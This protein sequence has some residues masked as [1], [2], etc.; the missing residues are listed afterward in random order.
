MQNKQWLV[1][2]T[3]AAAVAS[4]GCATIVH[5]GGGQE[6]AFTSSPPG[7]AVTIDNRVIGTTPTTAR[8]RRKTNH[9]VTLDLPGYASQSTTLDSGLSGWVFGNILLGGVI[10]LIVDA[11]TGGMY[12]L[13]PNGVHADFVPPAAAITPPL[14]APAATPVA[15][16]SVPSMPSPVAS[17]PA[18]PKT[19]APKFAKGSVVTLPAGAL[20]RDRPTANSSGHTTAQPEVVTLIS[21]NGTADTWWYVKGAV[22][23]GWLRAGELPRP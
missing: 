2:G 10:G 23:A 20:I 17:T 6:V 7:A 9:Y 4:S 21:E 11:S 13:S 1:A 8:L 19:A 18:A 22:T 15:A 16:A 14:A 12:T 3:L 5:G